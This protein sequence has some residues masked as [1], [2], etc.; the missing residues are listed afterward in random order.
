MEA[1]NQYMELLSKL[2]SGEIK[3]DRNAFEQRAIDNYNATVGDLEYYDCP[4]CLNRGDFMKLVEGHQTLYF[5][6]CMAIRRSNKLLLESGM[7][8]QI[9]EKTFENYVCD[10]P[11]QKYLKDK[12]RSFVDSPTNCLFLGGQSGSGKTHLCTAVC[13]RL[14]KQGKSL[15]YVL[16]RDIATKLQANIFND[17]KY[18][19]IADDLKN[20]EVLYID[21]MFK[22]ISTKSESGLKE[23]EIA[24]K[25]VNDRELSNKITIISTECT[26]ESLAKLDEAIAGRIVKM[27]TP[28][29]VLQVGKDPKRNFRLKSLQIL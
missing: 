11:W 13:G 16:W 8:Q 3:F 15:R 28:D 2:E 7:A 5:C 23:L 4:K 12:C 22:L 21:D 1:P 19:T 6:D 10:E 14:V 9:E 25:I 26:V 29:Y 17:E 24:F 27:A 20:V 18:T